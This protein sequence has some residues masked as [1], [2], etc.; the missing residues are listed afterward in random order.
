MFTG[1]VEDVGTVRSVKGS[2]AS[3]FLDIQT[4][5]DLKKEKVG[6]S[7]AVDG[8]C[9]TFVEIRGDVLKVEASVESLQ[10]T[11]LS[12]LRGGEKVNLE[13]AMKS[14]GRFGGHFVLG[15]VDGTGNITGI[16]EEQRGKIVSI[17]VPEG[18]E[19]YLVEKGSVTVDGVSLTTNKVQDR[20]FDV[21]L[22]SHTVQQTVFQY[23]KIGDP[24]NIETD[25]IGKYVRK[26]YKE[27]QNADS[28]GINETFL[29]EQGFF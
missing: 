15:H 29:K 16:R 11:T 8:A 23:K 4:H 22:L 2:S 10:K 3:T 5:I 26:W 20:S 7:I 14:D 12:R 19:V 21:F 27:S 13:L 18:L 9:L 25:L 17:I 28:E 6:D 1:I 24:V